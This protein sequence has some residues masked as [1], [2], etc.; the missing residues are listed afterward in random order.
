MEATLFI[1]ESIKRATGQVPGHERG[2]PGC[3][4]LRYHGIATLVQ[5]Q[6]IPPELYQRGL[7]LREWE[8]ILH[9]NNTRGQILYLG[10]QNAAGSACDHT[11]RKSWRAVFL[12][13]SLRDSGWGDPP[14]G[15]SPVIR[16]TAERPL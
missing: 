7:R 13:P 8:Q 14:R 15:K 3:V 9:P 4:T 12:W 2:K 16:G 6:S 10:L 1:F 5:Q 11:E